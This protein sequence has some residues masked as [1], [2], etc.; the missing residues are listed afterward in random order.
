[1]EF[2]IVLNGIFDFFKCWRL[3]VC[4]YNK[5]GFY[6]IVFLEIKS[7]SVFDLVFI[8]LNIVIDVVG[9]LDLSRGI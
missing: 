7:C 5:V 6:L 2:I 9:I 8:K 4:G 3:I 1:M